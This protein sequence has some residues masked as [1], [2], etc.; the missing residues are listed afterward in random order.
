MSHDIGS[1]IS[2]QSSTANKIRIGHDRSSLFVRGATSSAGN[3]MVIHSHP[4]ILRIARLDFLGLSLDRG[5][6]VLHHLDL[7]KRLASRLLLDLGMGG[8]LGGEVDQE[9]LA[10]AREQVALEQ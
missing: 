6:I 3:A 7:G 10:F 9:L 8:M 2:T 4:E 5:R 1:T